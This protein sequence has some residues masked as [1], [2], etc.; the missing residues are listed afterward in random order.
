MYPA[1]QNATDQTANFFWLLALLTIGLLVF[2]WIE[3]LPIVAAIFFIRHYE[4]DLIQF[5]VNAI[6]SMESWLHLPQMNAHS[7]TAIQH[8]MAHA[9]KKNVTFPQVGAISDEV[10]K[11]MRY[12]VMVILFFLAVWM[13]FRNKNSRFHH[14]YTMET[15]KKSEVEN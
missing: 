8:L 3:K 5:V 2:W 6:N 13:L 1:Q 14:I 10:G 7:L 4:I 9:D 15:L 12:P 11:W